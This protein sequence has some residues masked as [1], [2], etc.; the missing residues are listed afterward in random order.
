MERGMGSLRRSATFSDCLLGQ[1]GLCTRHTHGGLEMGGGAA[2]DA[3][4]Q[5]FPSAGLGPSWVGG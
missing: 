2:F 5:L 1:D 4:S 3:G